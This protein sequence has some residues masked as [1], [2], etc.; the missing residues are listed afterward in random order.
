VGLGHTTSDISVRGCI[1]SQYVRAEV[2][3]AAAPHCPLPG[4]KPTGNG[5]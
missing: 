1:R 3:G 2:T 4:G 5:L